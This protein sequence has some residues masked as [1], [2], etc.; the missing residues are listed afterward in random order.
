AH[1]TKINLYNACQF[2]VWPAWI[3]NAGVAQIAPGGAK[4]QPYE[5]IHLLAPW[6]WS[7]R[8]WG[9]TD[10]S[11]SIA[12]INSSNTANNHTMN[13]MIDCETGDCNGELGCSS[14]GLPPATLVEFTPLRD[15][16]ALLDHYDVSLVDGYNLPVRV[17]PSSGSCKSAG[18]SASAADLLARCPPELAIRRSGGDAGVIACKSPCLAFKEDRYYCTGEY[19]S[20]RKCRPS[21]YS[22]CF[23]RSCPDAYSYAFDSL[24]SG[25]A[26]P[27]GAEYTIVFCPRSYGHGSSESSSSW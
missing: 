11:S 27:S 12:A 13:T 3:P 5:S 26:C 21:P 25:F 19:G 6:G 16:H 9:R 17:I 8:F 10:C 22:R 14:P 24:D 20:A 2:P 15:P 18:C 7:G 4:I 1:Q 23:K